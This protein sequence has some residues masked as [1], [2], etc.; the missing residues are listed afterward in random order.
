[1]PVCKSG[2]CIYIEA[3]V[4]SL[5]ID[6]IKDAVSVAVD[7]YNNKRP[8]MSIDMMTRSQAAGYSGERMKQ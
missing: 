4:I 5:H 1:L 2:V 7:F 6:E 3:F 8:H